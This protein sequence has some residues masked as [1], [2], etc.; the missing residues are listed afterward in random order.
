MS[1]ISL[2][3]TRRSLLAMSAAAG[4]LSLLPAHLAAAVD[5]NAIRPFRVNVPEADLVDLRRRVLATRW[6]AKETVADQSQ[7]VQLA[8]LKELM[9]RTTTGGRWRR[10]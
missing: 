2:L 8:K 9:G 10:S 4:A 7:G 3:S 5:G 6:P 1:E